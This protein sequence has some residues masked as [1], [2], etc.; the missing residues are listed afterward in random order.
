MERGKDSKPWWFSDQVWERMCPLLPKYD[1]TPGP[2]G[3]RPRVSLRRVLNGILYVLR[4][5]CQWKLAPR[6][7][8][9]GSTLHR[10]FQEWVEHGVFRRFW[11][12]GLLQYEEVRGIKWDWQSIDAAITKAPLGGEKNRPQPHGSGQIGHQEIPRYGWRRRSGGPGDR[13][14]ESA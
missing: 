7:Y 5:G 12:A 3:G 11:E 1:P 10:Y 2:S 8:G 13:T 9:S 6:V 4:T 14:R